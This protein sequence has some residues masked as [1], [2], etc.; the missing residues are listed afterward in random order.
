MQE[1]EKGKFVDTF[2]KPGKFKESSKMTIVAWVAQ[3]QNLLIASH[4]LWNN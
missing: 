4:N 2:T 1:A 3:I